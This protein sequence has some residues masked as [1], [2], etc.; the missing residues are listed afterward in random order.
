[1]N[2]RIH[3]REA[4]RSLATFSLSIIAP[5]ALVGCSKKTSCLDVTGMSP[6]EVSQRSQIAD[7]VDVTP[8]AAKKCSRCLHYVPAAPNAC[9]GCK[10]VKGPINA[11]GTCKLF[12]AKPA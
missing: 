10:V 4:L 7:Y 12:V 9:G 11:E 6:D 1:M 8:D 2:D 5:P 3:R